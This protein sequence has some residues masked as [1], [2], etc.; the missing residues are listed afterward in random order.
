MPFQIN[1]FA[2]GSAH[3]RVGSGGEAV[4]GCPT[5]HMYRT[6]DAPTVVDAAG[7]FTAVRQH[8][9][10][11]DLIY[12]VTVNSSGVVQT[13]GFHV[14][15]TKTAASVDVSDLLALTVTNTRV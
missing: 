1:N 13:A 2:P 7:Y 4:P 10:V 14:V 8:L 6:E 5:M 12:R 15:M 11:G 9:Q 3:M